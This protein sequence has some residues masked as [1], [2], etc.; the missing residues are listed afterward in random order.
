MA[1][2]TAIIATTGGDVRWSHRRIHSGYIDVSWILDLFVYCL[3]SFFFFFFSVYPY[4]FLLKW[5][6]EQVLF[7]CKRGLVEFEHLPSTY[8]VVVATHLGVT[9]Q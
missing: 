7:I 8:L 2:T 1:A 9:F 4:V 5:D 6:E 3:I